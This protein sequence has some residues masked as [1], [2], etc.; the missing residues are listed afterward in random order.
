MQEA[1][2]HVAPSPQ[3]GADVLSTC[4]WKTTLRTLAVGKAHKVFICSNSDR[5]VTEGPAL[6]AFD[7]GEDFQIALLKLN[8]PAGAQGIQGELAI[9]WGLW[10]GCPSY[11]GKGIE[12]PSR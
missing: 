6:P 7:G 12:V 4:H 8:S 2:C 11:Q 9:V 10:G 5:Q 3:H 1:I